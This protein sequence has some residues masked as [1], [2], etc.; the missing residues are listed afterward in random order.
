MSK[1]TLRKDFFVQP[2][3]TEDQARALNDFLDRLV[4]AMPALR[5]GAYVG[6]GRE[7]EVELVDMTGPPLLVL[8]QAETGGVIYTALVPY[9]SG[10]ITAWSRKS[11]TLSAGAAHNAAS[12]SYRY[13]ILA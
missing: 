10:E 4:V 1:P 5:T 12:T 3:W 9:A 2:D 6:T 8:L 11:F 7:N 13:L